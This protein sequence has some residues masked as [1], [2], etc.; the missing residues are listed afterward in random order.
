M[1]IFLFSFIPTP[2]SSH[3]ILITGHHHCRSTT[4]IAWISSLGFHWRCDWILIDDV[5][6]RGYLS[7]INL[8]RNL[9]RRL[10]RVVAVV[11]V[12]LVH[13]PLLDGFA[14]HFIAPLGVFVSLSVYSWSRSITYLHPSP[15]ILRALSLS[16]SL[17]LSPSGSPCVVS[18]SIPRLPTPPPVCR[19][20]AH[21]LLSLR[22]P[23]ART[24]TVYP[25]NF[26]YPHLFARAFSA[27]R[28]RFLYLFRDSTEQRG[29]FRTRWNLP[30]RPRLF[31]ISRV[32]RATTI[33]H[34]R[35]S[36]RSAGL[37]P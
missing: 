23:S 8:N 14:T 30:F 32:S 9:G 6:A 20:A 28:T 19:A 4:W 18:P 31:E 27:F 25:Y 13:G 5:F 35:R 21:P 24:I 17:S 16:L 33:G 26:L 2:R 7:P 37:F 10:G 1:S 15:S 11:V 22:Q 29:Y 12:V 34:R 36:P 3:R